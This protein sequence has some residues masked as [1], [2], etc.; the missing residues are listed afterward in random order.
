MKPKGKGIL[1][2]LGTADDEEDEPKAKASAEEDDDYDEEGDEEALDAAQ[3]LLD[4]IDAKDTSGIV[5]A[6][7]RLK[8]SC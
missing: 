5:E 3:A 4:A 8:A 2:L 1:A 7:S 6:F